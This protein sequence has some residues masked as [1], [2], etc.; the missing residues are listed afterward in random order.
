MNSGNRFRLRKDTSLRQINRDC[1]RPAVRHAQP[2]LFGCTLIG[3]V[4]RMGCFS[5]GWSSGDG[6]QS[7]VGNIRKTDE[8]RPHLLMSGASVV[9]LPAESDWDPQLGFE[10]LI[11]PYKRTR[12]HTRRFC[13]TSLFGFVSAANIWGLCCCSGFCSVQFCTVS[14]PQNVMTTRHL[15][16]DSVN[17]RPQA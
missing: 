10:A 17:R 3:W 16:K 6:K 15:P 7:M 13:S 11:P 14:C 1:H 12:G 4:V 8:L 9:E 5:P 2:L